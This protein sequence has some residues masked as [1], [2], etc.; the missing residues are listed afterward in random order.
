MQF[1]SSVQ[2]SIVPYQAQVRGAKTG[3]VYNSY[4]LITG[5][6]S[7]SFHS[8]SSQ[9]LWGS[10]NWQYRLCWQY[11]T[12]TTYLGQADRQFST[13]TLNY[14]S[15]T[16]IK[17]EQEQKLT[18]RAA[19]YLRTW[20][21]VGFSLLLW[22]MSLMR[23]WGGGIVSWVGIRSLAWYLQVSIHILLLCVHSHSRY[24]LCVH[25]LFLWFS[26]YQVLYY[27]CSWLTWSWSSYI[28]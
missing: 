3:L 8:G 11:F 23:R 10:G 1:Y 7:C 18:I 12:L 16:G 6:L 9:K 2:N 4:R 25:L 28:G 21:R 14:N 24:T 26:Y 19:A 22:Q 5:L 17:Q 20:T 27:V 15:T 13:T